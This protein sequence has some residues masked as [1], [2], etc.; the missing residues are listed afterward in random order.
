MSLFKFP[1]TIYFQRDIIDSLEEIL[2]R[3]GVRRVLVITD[4]VLLNLIGGRIERAL[5]TLERDYFTDVSPEPSVDQIKK[6]MSGIKGKQYDAVIAIGGG[7]VID[8]SKAVA[9]LISNPEADL[10]TISPFESINLKT[11]IVAIP[12]TSGTG[13]D[14]SFGVVLSDKEGK[15]AMGNYDLVPEIDI[16][17]SSLTPVD[18][19]IIVPTGIDA[20]VHSF[21]AIASNT[22][23][24][25]TDALAERAI[26]N[27]FNNLK[28]AINN[29]ENAKD[30]MHISAT[31]AGIAFSNSGTA[32]AHALGHSFGATFHVTHG[33]SVGLFLVPTIIYNSQDPQTRE[34]YLRVCR[35][36]NVRDIS[37]LT[38][39]IRYFFSSVG[40]P[41]SVRDLGIDKQIYESKIDNLISLSQRDSELAFNPVLMG[42]EDLRKLFVENY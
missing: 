2:S 32:A 7:S 17:D 42:E 41:T 16:L 39:K 30:I 22:S 11:K 37:S 33:T 27:I 18:K 38:E 35:I 6:S 31:M 4:K 25:F 1:R 21:E 23:T 15:R 20:F 40:Q 14:V 8:F 12:T 34:K 29:D 36:L 26:E 9:V 10:T 13:S 28:G 3:E 24:V 5:G 19:R